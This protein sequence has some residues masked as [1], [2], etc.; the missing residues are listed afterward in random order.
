MEVMM[1]KSKL[2][3]AL[4][5]FVQAIV[6]I[7]EDTA[8]NTLAA[9]A[10]DLRTVGHSGRKPRDPDSLMAKNMRKAKSMTKPCPFPDCESMGSPRNGM[11]CAEHA[12]ISKKKKNALRFAAKQP[13]GKWSLKPAPKK[14]A[15]RTKPAPKKAGKKLASPTKKP[16]Q[17]KAATG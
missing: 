4:D 10:K 14:A 8:Q 11:M 6:G 9:R 3:T 16:S 15:K 13:G 5:E 1:S 12:N 7:A 2:E 17:A